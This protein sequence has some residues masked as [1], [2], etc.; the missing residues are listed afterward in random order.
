MVVERR[1]SVIQSSVCGNP[2]GED[3]RDKTKPFEIAKRDVWEAWKRVRSKHGG[4]GIDGQTVEDIEGDVGNQLYKLWNRMSSGS[5]MPQA[6]QRVEIPKADGGMR[7]LGIPSVIDRVAQTVVKQA[8][9]PVLERVFHSSSY[10][11][12]PGRS[13]KQAVMAARAHCWRYN[14]VVDIDIQAFFDSI[15]HTLLMKAVR[16]HT[17]CAW[18]LL[19]IDRWLK[20]EVVLAEGTVEERMRGTPQGGVISPLLANLYLH[21]AFDTWVDREFPDIRFERYADDIVCHC[22]SMARARKFLAALTERFTRCGL[23]LHP[24]K[25]RI[26]YCKDDKRRGQWEHTSFDFLG[27]TFRP[28]AACSRTGHRF[29][30]FNPA[31]SRR[32]LKRMGREIRHWNLQRR[33]DKRLADLGRMFNPILRGWINYFGWVNKSGL[34]ELLKRLNLRLARWAMNKYKKLRGHRRKARRW[35]RSYIRAHPRDF[36]HW[37]FIYPRMV[38]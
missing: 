33:T 19:Y 8:L 27:F 1:G 30:G 11:F 35:V 16:H 4:S 5:Y 10:G 18:M 22:H 28:R 24:Q 34:V 2:P 32:A 37:T 9:E 14:W 13:A 7:P 21:Y 17:D 36:A 20:A 3:R 38:G 15:D 12:R 31:V 29:V 26:A 6:V 23:T 25:T